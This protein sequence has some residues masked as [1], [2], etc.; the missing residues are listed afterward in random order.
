MFHI[1]IIDKEMLHALPKTNSVIIDISFLSWNTK[2]TTN[3]IIIFLNAVMHCK[4]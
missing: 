3:K 2:N 4:I 1:I